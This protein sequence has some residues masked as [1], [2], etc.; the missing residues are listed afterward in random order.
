MNSGVDIISARDKDLCNYTD[1]ELPAKAFSEKST[2]LL[3]ILTSNA[4]N[5]SNEPVGA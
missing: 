5:I 2:Y 4:C 3:M 1:S